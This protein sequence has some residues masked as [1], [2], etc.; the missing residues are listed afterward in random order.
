MNF[1]FVEIFLCLPPTGKIPFRSICL[2]VCLFFRPSVCLYVSLSIESTV[3]ISSM[4]IASILTTLYRPLPRMNP[5]GGIVLH[6]HISGFV[7]CCFCFVSGFVFVR[8]LNDF[9]K[10]FHVRYLTLKAL[11]VIAGRFC[12][13]HNSPPV[14]VSEIQ[15]SF[16]S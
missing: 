10:C 11:V 3:I 7:F 13:L 1:S 8:L 4:Y 16:I 9:L 2:F 15:P 14:P 5:A 12:Q 6:K